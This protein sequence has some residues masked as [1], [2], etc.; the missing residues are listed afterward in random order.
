MILLK[1]SFPHSLILPSLLSYLVATLVSHIPN[2]PNFLSVNNMHNLSACHLPF[3]FCYEALHLFSGF[4]VTKS[5]QIEDRTLRHKAKGGNWSL[6][7]FAS[8]MSRFGRGSW[9]KT[10]KTPE[11]INFIFVIQTLVTQKKWKPMFLFS[12]KLFFSLKHSFILLKHHQMVSPF[13]IVM[14]KERKKE[15][16]TKKEVKKRGERE[17]WN[18][19]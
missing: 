10:L 19:C 9:K 7:F 11:L 4:W 8:R 13:Q 17:P 12:H 15:E 3:T 5:P 2:L 16:R 1:N 14:N 6:S 18:W